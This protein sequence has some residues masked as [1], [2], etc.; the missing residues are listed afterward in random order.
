[1]TATRPTILA[2]SSGLRRDPRNPFDVRPGRLQEFAAELSGAGDE[3]RFSILHQAQGDSESRIGETYAAFARTRYRVSH[4]QLFPQPTTTTCGGCT[5]TA[6]NS[7][8]L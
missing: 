1:M 8:V 7:G 5:T 4:L 2:T 6:R 3:A